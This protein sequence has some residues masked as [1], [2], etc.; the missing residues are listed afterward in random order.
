MH[1]TFTIKIKTQKKIIM[2]YDNF[3]KFDYLNR[4][5]KNYTYFRDIHIIQ[6][7]K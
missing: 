5:H 1:E 6:K 4:F 7:I 3:H 2:N